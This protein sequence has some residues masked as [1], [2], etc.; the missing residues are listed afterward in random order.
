MALVSHADRGNPACYTVVVVSPLILL[1]S[2]SDWVG[3][4]ETKRRRRHLRPYFFLLQAVSPQEI[5]KAFHGTLTVLLISST[6]L[7]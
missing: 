1:V 5:L 6:Y 3:L 7:S 4:W 2:H